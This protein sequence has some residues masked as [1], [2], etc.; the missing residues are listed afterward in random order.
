MPNFRPEGLFG[1]NA[2]R[3]F[4]RNLRKNPN[5]DYYVLGSRQLAQ[6]IHTASRATVVEPSHATSHLSRTHL[7]NDELHARNGYVLAACLRFV[8]VRRRDVHVRDEPMPPMKRAMNSTTSKPA[9]AIN[10]SGERG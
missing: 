5:V 8:P 7:T 10:V 9:S 2:V 4:Q 6:S 3:K 1:S